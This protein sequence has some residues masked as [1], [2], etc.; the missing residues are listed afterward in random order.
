MFRNISGKKLVWPLLAGGAAYGLAAAKSR[1]GFT[2]LL[3]G[4]AAAFLMGKA[5][6]RGITWDDRLFGRDIM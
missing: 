5:V 2:P 1:R 3:I 4:G 6:S